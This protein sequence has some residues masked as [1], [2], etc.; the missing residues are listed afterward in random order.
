MD[1]T[2]SVVVEVKT[3][4]LRSELVKGVFQAVK[5]RALVAAQRGK[6]EPHEVKAFLVAFQIPHEV[7][8]YASCLSVIPLTIDK[9]AV[10]PSV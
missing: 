5:Y 3:E 6:G 2:S 10:T 7:A 9:R 4:V 8:Q 1:E